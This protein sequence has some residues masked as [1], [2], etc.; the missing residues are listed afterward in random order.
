MRKKYVVYITTNRINGKIYVGKDS[1]NNPEYLGSGNYF[2]AAVKKHGRENFTKAILE[3]CNDKEHMSER[4]IFWISKLNSMDRNVGYN[5]NK[6]GAGDWNNIERIG[7]TGYSLRSKKVH[8][9]LGVEGRKKMRINCNKTMYSKM[10]QEE[11]NAKMEIAR[12]NITS[13]SRKK[14][15]ITHSANKEAKFM[16]QWENIKVIQKNSLGEVVYIWK[17]LLE[18]KK[19]LSNYFTGILRV[20]RGERKRAHVNG[21][22]FT[23]ELVN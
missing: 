7:K 2:K 18:I 10:T 23:W 3:Y 21:E 20:L 14:G 5:Q 19:E 22:K 15:A 6:G 13:E 8:E 12:K 4:E 9:S 11:K 1:A 17:D 16:K